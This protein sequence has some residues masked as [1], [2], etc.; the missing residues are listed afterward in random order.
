MSSSGFFL[1]IASVPQ[2]PAGK[3]FLPG[4]YVAESP[5]TIDTTAGG[6][7][8]IPA[9]AVN[10]TRFITLRCSGADILIS[11][12]GT[13]T[14]TNFAFRFTPD[15][16]LVGAMVNSQEWKAIAASGT[17]TIQVFIAPA[18]AVEVV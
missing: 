15:M 5:V 18:V 8:I 1:P 6:S 14:T 16:Q 4:D 3:I 10:A 9:D 7:V 11:L 13:P 12:G 2:A 17:A